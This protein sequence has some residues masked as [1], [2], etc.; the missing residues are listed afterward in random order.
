M[1]EALTVNRMNLHLGRLR[2]IRPLYDNDPDSVLMERFCYEAAKRGAV[3]SERI[4]AGGVGFA[5]P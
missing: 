2:L 3:L 5:S 4:I 1:G